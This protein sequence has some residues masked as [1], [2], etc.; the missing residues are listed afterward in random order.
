MRETR[1]TSLRSLCSSLTHGL[2][3]GVLILFALAGS[4][5]VGLWLQTCVAGR[6]CTKCAE[7]CCGEKQD[8]C[9]CRHTGTDGCTCNPTRGIR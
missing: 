5:Q 6:T 7:D 8:R 1:E 9:S 4:Y 2:C 3:S